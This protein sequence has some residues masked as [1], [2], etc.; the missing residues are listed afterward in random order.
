M[1]VGGEIEQFDDGTL[2]SA[3]KNRVPVSSDLLYFFF[4]LFLC[5]NGSV[6][7]DGCSLPLKTKSQAV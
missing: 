2:I 3:F 5:N 6:Y 4:N 7:P 1:P